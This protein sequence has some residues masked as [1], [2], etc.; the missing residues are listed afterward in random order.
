MSKIVNKTAGVIILGDGTVL[1]PGVATAI[2]ASAEKDSLVVALLDGGKL[3][4]ADAGVAEAEAALAGVKD[5]AAL[6]QVTK[7]GK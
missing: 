1:V 5:K 4:V 7:A 6:A 2:S 3:E